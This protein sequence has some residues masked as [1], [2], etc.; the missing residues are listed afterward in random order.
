MTPRNRSGLSRT[1]YP[2][3]PRCSGPVA[4][5]MM[6]SHSVDLGFGAA[7]RRIYYHPDAISMYCVSASCNWDQ[8]AAKLTTP[9]PAEDDAL[10]VFLCPRCLIVGATVEGSP[11]AVCEAKP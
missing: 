9:A 1:D 5:A 10:Q 3:C 2:I 7:P 8:P 4:V 11:C 6:T